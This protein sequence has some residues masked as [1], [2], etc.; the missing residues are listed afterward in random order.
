MAF[1][2]MATRV[3]YADLRVGLEQEKLLLVLHHMIVCVNKIFVSVPMASKAK[4]R[5]VCLTMLIFARS[6]TMGF[7]WPVLLV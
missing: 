4:G 6:A 5:S 2:E 1:I 3:L 7:T